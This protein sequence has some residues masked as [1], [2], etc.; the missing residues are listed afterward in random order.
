[1]ED[2]VHDLASLYEFGCL[3]HILSWLSI[4]DLCALS[5]CSRFWKDVCNRDC[6]WRLQA[7]RIVGRKVF[8]AAIVEG[9]TT[10]GNGRG[11]PRLDLLALSAKQLRDRCSQYG[12]TAERG[13]EKSEICALIDRYELSFS[14][15]DECL[16]CFA[17]RIAIRDATRNQISAAELCSITWRHRIRLDGPLNHIADHDPWYNSATGDVGSTVSFFPGRRDNVGT[18]KYTLRDDS[19]L[20]LLGP[21]FLVLQ[22]LN[23][24][25]WVLQ[26]Q[27]LELTPLGIQAII[28]R[29]PITWGWVLILPASLWT[30]WPMPARGTDPLLEDFNLHRLVKPLDAGFSFNKSK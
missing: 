27:T 20:R 13:A 16:A 23:D 3:D 24:L 22:Q 21:Q 15:A 25:Q 17:T 28:C 26:G 14:T 12:I 6:V 18:F 11:L 5:A 8:V 4:N 19:P 1:M 7:R 9:L 29:H 10:P 30:S 2:L